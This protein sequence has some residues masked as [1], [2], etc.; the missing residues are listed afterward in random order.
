VIPVSAIRE[1]MTQKIWTL[2]PLALK[3]A[4]FLAAESEHPDTVVRGRMVRRGQYLRSLKGLATELS[5]DY[6]TLKKALLDL[7]RARYI[8]VERPTHSVAR[9]RQ[10]QLINVFAS[11]HLQRA[12]A[13][14]VGKR[15]SYG[16]R[17]SS[18]HPTGTPNSAAGRSDNEA[19]RS[20]LNLHARARAREARDG[21]SYE[22]ALRALQ[23]G[24]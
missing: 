24:K 7:M 22:E 12:P 20:V 1:L 15:V 16:N 17:T 19:D 21:I 14:N 3:L 4:L 8:S 11:R 9:N 10:E 13:R 23:A 2:S 5:V 18:L 6:R